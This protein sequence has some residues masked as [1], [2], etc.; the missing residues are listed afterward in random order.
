MGAT[1]CPETS[2]NF[3]HFKPRKAQRHQNLKGLCFDYKGETIDDVV[4][5]KTRFIL[6]RTQNV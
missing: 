5:N 2:V 6:R 3:N 4:G 1:I